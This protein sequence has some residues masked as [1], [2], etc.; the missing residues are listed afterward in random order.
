MTVIVQVLLLILGFILL[1]QGAN[2][3]VSAS[4]GIAKK[5]RI[6]GV[7]IG[8][9]IVA[10]GT[11]APEA[12]VSIIAASK[13]S[14]DI[15][16]GNIV[17]S[18]IFNLLLVVGICALIKPFAVR[19]KEISG[20]FLV[21]AGAAGTLLVMAVFSAIFDD[22]A[23]GIILRISSALLLFV[24]VIYMFVLIKKTAKEKDAER[25]EERQVNRVSVRPLPLSILLAVTGCA[26]VILGGQ[27]TVNSASKI[28][29][30]LGV[31]E[32][33]IG[34]TIVAVGT[35]LPEFVVSI[36]ACKKGESE[37]AL[38]NVIGSN[39]FNILF[40]LGLAGVISPLTAGAGINMIPD[41]ILLILSS[42][43][44]L[45]FVYSGR[46]LV[47]TEGFVMVIAYTAYI[48]YTVAV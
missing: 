6:P 22:P 31:D 4:V 15:A 21:S 5:L 10:A 19:L 44:V 8:L 27:F 48:I 11:S 43:L 1:I 36:V 41:I 45:F 3:F 17:G 23:K 12:V 33:I 18:N 24:F 47:R 13:G 39:I 32:R 7:I 14:N 16:A 25:D 46:R 2:V 40:I 30:W 26:L 28:A 38:G 42:L 29:A 35:S 9:T 34:L 37:I 20:D